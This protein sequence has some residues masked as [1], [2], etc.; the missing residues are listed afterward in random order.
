[1]TAWC[2]GCCSSFAESYAVLSAEWL[3]GTTGRAPNNFD[4]AQF[5]ADLAAI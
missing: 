2:G 1:M 4:L 5:E 3:N